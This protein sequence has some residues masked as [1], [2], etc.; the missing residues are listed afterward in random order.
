MQIDDMILNLDANHMNFD[1][2]KSI[3]LYRLLQ[4]KKITKEIFETYNTK[5]NI[6]IVKKNW[7]KSWAQKFWGSKI[8]DENISDYQFRFVKFE[9]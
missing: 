2:V 9:D 8:K 3:I 6:I 1:C 7:F 4:D 5:W